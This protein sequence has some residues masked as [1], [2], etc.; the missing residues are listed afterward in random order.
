[1]EFEGWSVKPLFLGSASFFNRSLDDSAF[2]P[3]PFFT[4]AFVLSFSLLAFTVLG[5]SVP[6]AVLAGSFVRGEEDAGSA[7]LN[8]EL[9]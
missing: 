3:F 8:F 4:S 7:S 2:P 1:L 6:V 5:G 9:L